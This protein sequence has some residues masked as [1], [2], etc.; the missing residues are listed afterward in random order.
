MKALLIIAN[1]KEEQVLTSHIQLLHTTPHILESVITVLDEALDLSPE[2]AV[3]FH[4]HPKR[5]LIPIY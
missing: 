3:F 5:K 2:L 1:V 4:K